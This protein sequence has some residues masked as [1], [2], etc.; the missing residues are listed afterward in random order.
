MEWTTAHLSKHGSDSPRL[1]AEIL[2]AHAR[3]CKRIELYTRFEE[4]LTE[5]QRGSMRELVQRRAKVEPVAYL[6]GH[7][8]FYGL[9]FRVTKDVLSP[10]PT[11]KRLVMELLRSPSRRIRRGLLDVGTGSGCI[12]V[13]IATN[14]KSAQLT[15]GD[16]SEYRTC[17]R[18]GKRGN[19][20]SRR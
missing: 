6:V 17:D 12:A 3:Q 18:Q 1:D 14:L 2:L 15:A 11:P 13:A 4:V 8:E 9:P 19:Q 10:A 5:E 7:R 20:Q 16:I